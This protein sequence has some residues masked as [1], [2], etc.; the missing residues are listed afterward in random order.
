MASLAV[1]STAG[2]SCRFILKNAVERNAQIV[3]PHPRPFSRREKGANPLALNCGFQVQHA[4]R[5]GGQGFISHAR[6]ITDGQKPVNAGFLYLARQGDR[7][8]GSSSMQATEYISI[9]LPDR[10]DSYLIYIKDDGY[11]CAL[12]WLQ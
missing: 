6:S 8:T 1:P 7:N 4:K 12:D 3:G 11:P 2:S 5:A 9:Y 10:R